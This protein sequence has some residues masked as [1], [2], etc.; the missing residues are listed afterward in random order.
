MWRKSKRYNLGRKSVLHLMDLHCQNDAPIKLV[1]QLHESIPFMVL[2]CL[3]L[4][5]VLHKG[6]DGRKKWLGLILS[7]ERN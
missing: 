3:M 4:S 6:I 5:F 7:S 1:K 2:G